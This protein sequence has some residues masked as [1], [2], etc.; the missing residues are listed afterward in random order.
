MAKRKDK[1]AERAR[2]IFNKANTAT[3]VQWETV[4]QKGFDFAND[5]Q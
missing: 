3:R 4:N 1:Q 2:E 5:N